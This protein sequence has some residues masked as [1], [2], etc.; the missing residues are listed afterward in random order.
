MGLKKRVSFDWLLKIG[1][2]LVLAFLGL[3][4]IIFGSYKLLNDSRLGVVFNGSTTTTV[5]FLNHKSV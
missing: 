4:G 1:I 3:F 2:I 5:Y